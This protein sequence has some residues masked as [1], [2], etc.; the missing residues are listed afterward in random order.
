MLILYLVI[1]SFVGSIGGVLGAYLLLSLGKK[2]QKDLI[3]EL[4]PFASGAMLA[5]ALLGLLPSALEALEAKVVFSIL[6]AGLFGFFLLEKII[7]WRHCHSDDCGKHSHPRATLV[8]IGDAF[9]N[10]IDG[11]AIAGSFMISIPFG[12]VASLAIFS[13]EIPQE[14]G[15]FGILLHSGYTRQKALAMNILSGLATF[16]GV[17]LGYFLLDKIQNAVPV[18]AIIA[19]ASFIYIS[20]A[21]LS[22][23]LH[24]KTSPKDIVKQLSLMILGA[25]IIAFLLQF[26]AD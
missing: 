14:L 13:H 3:A 10:F 21:D 20:L 18:V 2:M 25:V 17:I 22:P 5:S 4:L 16:P 19:S 11:V 9:H 24:K 6:L 1:F 15:D 12:V 7:I 23:E 8:I 26:H